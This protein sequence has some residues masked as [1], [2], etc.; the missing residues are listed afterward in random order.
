MEKFKIGTSEYEIREFEKG[1]DSIKELT[2]LLHKAYKRLA[3][4]G[5]NFVATYQDEEYTERYL[6]NGRCFI[7]LMDCKLVGTIFY[8]THNWD[9]IPEILKRDDAVL[10]GKFAVEPKL[11]NQGLGS[12]LMDFVEKHALENGKKEIVLDTSEKAGHLNDYYTKRGYRFVQYWQWPDVNYRSI[13]MSKK[14]Q[15]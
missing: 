8:Y 10:F 15:S 14:L 13:V 5:L 1:K 2:E 7:L 6:K 11:Q 12:K 3:D 4:M 9:D